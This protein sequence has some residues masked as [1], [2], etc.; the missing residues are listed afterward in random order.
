MASRP[1][2]PPAS[3]RSRAKPLDFGDAD[4]V[5]D[6]LGEPNMPLSP[7]DA[8]RIGGARWL[9]LQIEG[10]RTTSTFMRPARMQA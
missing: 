8:A 10:V 3:T 5:V 2:R 9:G 6:S 4:L 1:P 7:R